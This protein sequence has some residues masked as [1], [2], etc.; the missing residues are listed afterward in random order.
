METNS[1]PQ[2]SARVSPALL[3]FLIF[4]LVGIAA[5]VVMAL[6]SPQA[7]TAPGVVA[8]EQSAPRLL[9]WNAPDFQLP[10]LDGE[11]VRLSDYRGRP[12]FLNF[13]ATWC[14]PCKEEF[15]AFEQ[16][17]QEQ[18]ANGAMVLA[19]NTEDN[20]DA[21]RRFFASIGV[22]NLR[23]LLDTDLRVQRA[24]GI[25]NIPITFIIDAEGVVRYFR[26]G[27]MTVADM[28]DYLESLAKS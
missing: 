17:M 16:F 12:V 1:T 8:V 23:A 20:A 27:A 15:P 11:N 25:V 10:D 28:Y 19:V 9:N 18:G 24:Y 14:E 22:Q 4:P 7:N 13:W 3:I 5:A 21:I 26:P 2:P 6:S